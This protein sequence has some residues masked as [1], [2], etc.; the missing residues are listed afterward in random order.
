MNN[1][2]NC[3]GAGALLAADD[4]TFDATSVVN[5]AATANLA[6]NSV[7]IAAAYTGTWALTGFTATFGNGFSD[8]GTT[9][10]HNYG[11][12]ITCNGASGTFHVGAGVGTIVANCVLT[13]NTLT[14]GV[15]DDDKGI[16]IAQLILGENAA[17]NFTGS[18]F[19][20]ITNSSNIFILGANSALTFSSTVL[21]Y[22]LN[23]GDI[24]TAGTG[25]SISIAAGK[26]LTC[27]IIAGTAVTV[28]TITASGAGTI[29]FITFSNAAEI[30][31][32]GHQSYG[33]LAFKLGC[34]H[35]TGTSVINLNNY[36]ITCGALSMGNGLATGGT[37]NCGSGTIT[38]A[39]F[40]G[41]DYNVATCN[42]NMQSSQWNVS[43][44]M[45]LGSNHTVSPGSSIVTITGTSTVT[46]NGK[47]FFDL[48]INSVAL[49]VTCVDALALDAGG[50]LTLTSGTLNLSTFALTVGGATAINGTSTLNATGSTC[51]FGGN[52]TTAAGS[53]VTIN[54]ATN[55]T[56]TGVAVV[57]TNGK[58]LPQ[59]TFNANFTINDSCTIARLIFGVDGIT[60]TF[61][62][63]Q[64]FVI[65]ALTAANWNGSAG[66]LNAFRS[67][68]PGT[69]YTFTI[70]NAVT[71]SYVN[72]QDSNLS[73]AFQI[74]C[75]DGTSRNGGNNDVD[76]LFPA[77][78]GVGQRIS[79]SR[80]CIP[81]G[82]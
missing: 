36:N 66:A 75:M 71:L 58:A 42:F 50:D 7:T 39:S 70:P 25:S 81:I 38:C 40:T 26:V 29:Q 4:L 33:T 43:G 14:A 41:A 68:A 28:P 16:S 32:S 46:S 11:N 44:N 60:G 65:S 67:S 3:T 56:F 27:R 13:M 82:I 51:S 5:A 62:A 74:D 10:A 37:I 53:T 69:Q 79:K 54:A 24:W 35:T 61:E 52:Y 77:P 23:G 47:S 45:T 1:A 78:S 34:Y 64:T 72:P 9:G 21:A 76:W 31:L 2:A 63:G 12:G 15:I 80:I 48:T 57:T 17:A 49:T 22:F 8:D 30:R 20:S 59:C 73:A 18:A 19:T 55:Y 6:V